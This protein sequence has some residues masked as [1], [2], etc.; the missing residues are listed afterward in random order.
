MAQIIKKQT[1][2][3]DED[4]GGGKI[5]QICE[6]NSTSEQ[7]KIITDSNEICLP[8]SE[9]SLLFNLINE[10]LKVKGHNL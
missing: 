6:Y 10:T 2:I 4:F 1:F 8:T 5:T 9:W 7:I 3:R